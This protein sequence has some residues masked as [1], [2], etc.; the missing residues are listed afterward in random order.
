MSAVDFWEETP[1]IF[2]IFVK[3]N[4]KTPGCVP[5]RCAA[6]NRLGNNA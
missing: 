4:G 6:L 5:Q 2:V 1:A 3:E